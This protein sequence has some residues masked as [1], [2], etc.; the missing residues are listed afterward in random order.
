MRARILLFILVI[1]VTFVRGQKTF[2][3]ASFFA[4]IASE[5]LSLVNNQISSLKKLAIKEKE[6]YVGALM[7]KKAGLVSPIRT[8]LN[9]FKEGHAKLQAAIEK[10]PTNGT[11][12]FLR[13]I[14]QENAPKILNYNDD[15][16]EDSRYVN[17]VFDT[18]SPVVKNAALDYGKRSKALRIEKIAG[19]S[20]SKT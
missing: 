6:A 5:D 16:P 4:A 12:R 14:I 8:K 20:S 1:S 10:D 18:L 19:D 11:Y 2:N 17:Q 15:I 3:E 9:L 13:L 7:M